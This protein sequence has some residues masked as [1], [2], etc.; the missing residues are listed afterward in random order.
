VVWLEVANGLYFAMTQRFFLGRQ[1]VLDLVYLQ[2]WLCF[3]IEAVLVTQ[4][5]KNF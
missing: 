2:F 5:F 4:V 3:Q 1:I